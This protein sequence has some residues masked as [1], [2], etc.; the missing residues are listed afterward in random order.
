MYKF[1]IFMVIFQIEL[2][3]ISNIPARKPFL[4]LLFYPFFGKDGLLIHS[5]DSPWNS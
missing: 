4:N 1:F 3:K 2:E 5:I